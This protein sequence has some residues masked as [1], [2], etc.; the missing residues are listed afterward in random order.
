M[1]PVLRDVAAAIGDKGKVIKINV[2]KNN[3]LKEALRVKALPTLMIYNLMTILILLKQCG[4][5]QLPLAMETMNVQ[6]ENLL[7]HNVPLPRIY[8]V[9]VVIEY[10][11][12][13][14][15]KNGRGFNNEYTQGH[16]WKISSSRRRNLLS[17]C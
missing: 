3:E 4:R 8:I 12:L 14:M 9:K 1:H 15:S 13:A 5:V 11:S 16:L 2:D 17:I 10:L 7:S 6:Q